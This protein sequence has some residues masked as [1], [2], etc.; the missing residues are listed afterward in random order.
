M[1]QKKHNDILVGASLVIYQDPFTR[2]T[3]EG[4]AVVLEVIR[5]DI[6]DGIRC[7]DAWVRFDG[8]PSGRAYRTIAHID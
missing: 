5:R 6:Q 3:P 7:V 4:R 8:E 1:G 2:Q